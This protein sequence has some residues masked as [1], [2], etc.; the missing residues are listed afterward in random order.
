M[1]S[2]I[3]SRAFCLSMTFSRA[4][5]SAICKS[6][7]L[8]AL[9]AMGLLL[10]LP[11]RLAARG[12]RLGRI[13][14]VRFGVVSGARGGAPAQGFADQ[15]VGQDEARL[16]DLVHRQPRHALLGL[17]RVGQ[18]DQNLA[19]LGAPDEAAEALAAVQR[20]RHLDLGVVPGPAVEIAGP[21]E[22]AVDARRG[23][24][25]IIGL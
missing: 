3:A 21:D 25:Q 16:A 9:T 11:G 6:S 7:S 17:L 8:L 14:G 2:A 12:G 24:L 18:L 19:A 1:A 13:G 5:A 22:G 4:T 23:D 20:H 10:L 15:L